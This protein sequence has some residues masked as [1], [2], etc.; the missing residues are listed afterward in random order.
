MVGRAINEFVAAVAI[1]A[2][3]LSIL[4]IIPSFAIAKLRGHRFTYHVRSASIL[5][6][7][8]TLLLASSAAVS[9]LQR[10]TLS[11]VLNGMTVTEK[12]RY[13][14]ILK[15]AMSEPDKVTPEVYREFWQIIG[16]NGKVPAAEL[17]KLHDEV[18]DVMGVYQKY[19]YQ[20]ILTTLRTGQPFKSV[21]REKYEQGMLRR[22][23]A[24]KAAVDRND[25]YILHVAQGK[26]ISGG[27][28]PGPTVITEEIAEAVLENLET[29]IAAIDRLLTPPIGW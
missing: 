2:F 20:D 18:V 4:F 26:P 25:N 5:V 12:A 24:D 10:R 8:L 3:V 11:D 19:Y 21:E 17:K 13:N 9:A 7:I 6:V 15:L 14:D 16:K 29:K 23:V 28:L 1:N 22:G 27:T